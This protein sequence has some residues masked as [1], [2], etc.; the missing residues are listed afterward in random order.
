[1]YL[2]PVKAWCRRSDR[3]SWRELNGVRSVSLSGGNLVLVV[4]RAEACWWSWANLL[5]P[6]LVA[7][8]IEAG[9]VWTV[10]VEV[11]GVP[12]SISTCEFDVLVNQVRR[13]AFSR[14]TVYGVLRARLWPGKIL[15]STCVF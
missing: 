8:P 7:D 15:K 5:Y 13:S 14:D 10:K 4:D 2:G 12:S 1:M 11:P 6:I 3:D 9:E